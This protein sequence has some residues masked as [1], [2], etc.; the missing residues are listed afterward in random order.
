MY[1]TYVRLIY[2]LSLLNPWSSNSYP[3]E[4]QCLMFGKD[5]LW[6]QGYLESRNLG[7]K[8]TEIKKYH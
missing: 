6:C 7:K 3:H 4:I 8:I 2:I 1:I 5:L